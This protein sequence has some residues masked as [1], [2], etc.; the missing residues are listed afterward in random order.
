[1]SDRD[2]QEVLARGT[3]SRQLNLLERLFKLATVVLAGFILAAVLLIVGRSAST[4]SGG[5]GPHYC[6]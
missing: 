3:I 2:V 5:K 4:N 6:D 1:M